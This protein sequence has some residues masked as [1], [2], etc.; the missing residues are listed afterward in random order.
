[1]KL[2]KKLLALAMAATLVFALASCGETT[3]KDVYTV[4]ISQIVAHPALDAATEGFKQA[5][6]DILGEDKVEFKVQNAANSPDTCVTIANTFVTQNVDLIMA[7]G[8]PALQA[9]ANA[10]MDIPVL[11]TSI[12][13]YTVALGL[14]ESTFNGVVGGNISGASDLAP[15]DQ[16]ADMI[17]DLLPEAKTVGLLYC[18]A[19]PNS[20]YQVA[21]V[22][23]HLEAKNITCK[24]YAFA[25]SEDVVTVTQKAAA[26]C[27]ALY[28]PTDN[29]AASCAQT[30]YG[31]MTEKKPII[32]GEEGICSGC[33]IA[34]LS[35]S[36]YDL[37]YLTGEMAA[38]ILTGEADVSEM[39]IGYVDKFTK[40]YN[41]A[42]CEE[43]G[44][45]TAE[46]ELKGYV[47]I[48]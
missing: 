14:D 19:E 35:I 13:A 43:L 4:G 37:G 31:A 42:I 18:S 8:T 33:G 46:L 38:K 28:I 23:A 36:Y 34:T 21:Q 11:G 45:N 5:L 7:N 20:T 10:T 29:T 9:A 3:E 30:I 2:F 24:E 48:Q 6:I 17:V 15:L 32:A 16:Q 44:I 39:E 12:T 27:D 26:E 47:A 40:K 1:M 22:K 25:G 41:K